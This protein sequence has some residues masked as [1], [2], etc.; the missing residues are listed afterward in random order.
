MIQLFNLPGKDTVCSSPKTDPLAIHSSYYA[1]SPYLSDVTHHVDDP[2]AVDNPSCVDCPYCVDY[3]SCAECPRCI[4]YPPGF[5]CPPSVDCLPGVDSPHGVDDSPPSVDDLPP[6]VDDPPLRADSPSPRVIGP[7]DLPQELR[8]EIYGFFLQEEIKPTPHRITLV[9]EQNVK[10]SL[11]LQSYT[12]LLS[13]LLVNLQIRREVNE[14]I[15]HLFAGKLLKFELELTF[16]N[17]CSFFWVTWK[18]FTAL[19]PIVN[20][21]MININL[22]LGES[23]GDFLPNTNCLDDLL[24]N[25]EGDFAHEVFDYI[26]VLSKVLVSLLAD[27]NPG[28]RKLTIELMILNIRH[29]TVRLPG[30]TPGSLGRRVKVGYKAAKIVVQNMKNSLRRSF[31]GLQVNNSSKCDPLLP[32]VHV[33]ILRFTTKDGLWGEVHNVVFTGDRLG[34]VKAPPPSVRRLPRRRSSLRRRRRRG[35]TQPRPPT[36]SPASESD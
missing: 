29:P 33:V 30:S 14:A 31:G 19:S 5:N 6:S 2:R 22:C 28:N 25:K 10:D 8:D 9:S 4:D 23:I 36:P 20:Y 34:R 32:H 15:Q 24:G 18:Q 12:S 3:S 35:T 26:I 7:L 17:G 27:Q 13:L 1:E 11:P 16:L 21:V